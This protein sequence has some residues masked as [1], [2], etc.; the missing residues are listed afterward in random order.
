MGRNERFGFSVYKILNYVINFHCR[1]E[2]TIVK[3]GTIIIALMLVIVL[4]G[5]GGFLIVLRFDIFK[6]DVHL[7][8]REISILKTL[9]DSALVH[10]DVPVASVLLYNDSIIGTGYNTVLARNDAG[11]HAEINSISS[12][13]ASLG[14]KRFDA[15]DR[16]KLVLVSTFEPCLMCQGAFI[17]YRINRVIFL[18]SKPLSVRTRQ[19]LRQLRYE[20]MKRKGQPASLQDS[21]FFR[22]PLYHK[23]A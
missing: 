23:G 1:K 18:K 16:K 17:E 8:Q 14:K 22:H 10:L 6:P 2:H 11:G 12:A 15:L 3:R 19:Y 4:A 5:A 13:I 21:L 7:D 20:L 9:G